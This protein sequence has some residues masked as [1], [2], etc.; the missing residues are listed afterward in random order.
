MP[1]PYPVMLMVRELGL[2]GTERQLTEIAK[3]LDRDR[4][5]PHVGCFIPEGVRGDEL[6]ALGVPIARFP[7]RS[8]RSLAALEAARQFGHY[9]SKHY[10]S[11]V[12]TF[13]AP[14]NLFGVPAARIFGAP[15]VVSSQRCHRKLFREP[16]RHLLRMT[17]QMVDAVVANCGAVRRHLIEDER[18]ASHR[19]HVCYNG[20]DPAV[21]R[22]RTVSRP[23]ELRDADVIIG[24]VAAIRPEKDLNT[25]LN[26]FALVRAQRRG[27][28][29]VIVGDG[30]A[31]PALERRRAE[32]GLEQDCLL[33]PAAGDVSRWLSVIDV[34]VLSS[35]SEALSNALMEA[36]A[37]GCCVV[38]TRVGGTPELIT[39]GRTGLLFEPGRAD[40][41]AA[42]LARLATENGLRTRM[43][44]AGS[45]FIREEFSIE[46][47]TLRIADLYTGLL[48]RWSGR[49]R[50]A[51]R[52]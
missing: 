15:V 16:E 38:A 6:R 10:I 8:F 36:M 29:L 1:K 9:L 17:D 33:E 50:Q 20:I 47:S 2:G 45:Q 30:P 22:P 48:D 23:Q 28:K 27:V 3:N 37:C 19:I 39:H 44:E 51:R 25:L 18:V 11:L 40:E 52:A 46:A 43:A 42:H 5:E 14:A 49:S 4:F 34:F 7:V 12:H 41:L 26:A 24:T 32:L 35:I 31:F 21:F 13:D